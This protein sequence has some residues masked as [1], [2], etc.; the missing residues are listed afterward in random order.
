MIDQEFDST[1]MADASFFD[2]P[3]EASLKK[4]RIV[5][6]YFGGWA[7]IIL[8]ET[9]PK[10]GKIMYVDLFCGPGRYLDGTP[11]TPLLNKPRGP[12]T[13]SRFAAAKL[14]AESE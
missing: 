10:E 3:T 7:N 9:L 6:K 2:A 14:D 1:G 13:G 8:P 5:S 4:H 11:S 12:K